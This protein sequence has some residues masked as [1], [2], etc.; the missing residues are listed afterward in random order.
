MQVAFTIC[1]NNYLAQAK[2]LYLSLKE[3][4]PDEPFFIFL[5][6][7]KRPEI[8]YSSLADE[9]IP[10]ADIEPGIQ[11][12]AL[13]Y[14]IVELNTCVK[15]RVIEYLF[16]EKKMEKVL[17]LDPDICVY[18]PLTDLYT[19]L[20]T[21]DILLTP[22]IYT[23]IP[24]DGKK[25]AEHTFLNYGIYNLGF[26]GLSNREEAQ[27]FVSWWKEHTYK[28]GYIAAEQGIFVD[29]LPVNHAPLFF[30]NV[31]I[32][33]N[34]GANMAPWNL[35]ERTLSRQAGKYMVNEKEALMFYHFSSFAVDKNE[36]PLH[37]YDRF[38]LA[39]R[40]DLHA[41]HAAYNDAL[42]TAGHAFY[43]PFES[44]YSVMRKAYLKQLK[45]AQRPVRRILKKFFPG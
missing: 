15:P 41:L 18:G 12:L 22:H 13:R 39:A 6:D 21:A 26:I 20:D 24:I 42:K 4:Q 25:P 44:S 19:A 34:R 43:Q 32:L 16:G 23:P 2:V 40:P 35:H 9:V 37:H 36:L 33:Q 8:D 29:Q 7:E 17:Y 5:C 45:K 11:E 10:V 31:H 3:H 14:N 27:R 1:S 28:E 38:K 30:K